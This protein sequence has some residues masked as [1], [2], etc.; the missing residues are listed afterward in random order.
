MTDVLAPIA[1]KLAAAVRML[2]SD[3]DGDIV[4]AARAMYAC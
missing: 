4:A 1:N 3:R 2:S